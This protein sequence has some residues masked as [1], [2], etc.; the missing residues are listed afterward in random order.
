MTPGLHARVRMDATQ[1]DRLVLELD[2]SN[3][4]SFATQQ[5]LNTT[6]VSPQG[7]RFVSA[8]IIGPETLPGASSLGVQMALL[9]DRVVDPVSAQDPTNYQMPANAVQKAKSQLSG[10]I[11]VANLQEPEGPYVASSV[12]V[13]GISD[14][15]GATGSSASV[16]LQTKI[17]DPG[18]VVLGRVF[19]AD[20]TP[21]SS[22][23]VTYSTIPPAPDCA[24]EQDEQPVGVS[25][26]QVSADGRYEFRY[27]H[28]DSCG[29]PF[30]ISTQDPNT[31]GLRQLSNFVRIPGQQLIMDIPILGNL[32]R[33]K[34][35]QKSAT[36]LVVLCTVHRISPSTEPSPT[37]KYPQPFMD[38]GKFDGAAAPG[39]GK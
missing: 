33:S 13:S 17:Q 30:Q 25:S 26:V 10:R 29:M 39:G 20:G 15:R 3:D 36:E 21:V 14:A 8:T 34:N 28:Q 7:P 27:V 31:G 38:K 6:I 18:A 1:S 22:A 12:T 19:N 16:P 24:T 32:F 9:F 23:V 37:P 11:V 35:A 4:G 5:P 2:T